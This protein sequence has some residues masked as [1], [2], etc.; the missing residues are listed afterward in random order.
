[1]KNIGF[2]ILMHIDPFTHEA[3]IEA[4]TNDEDLK[5]VFNQLKN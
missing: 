2:E 1:M 3:Y 5:E 4:Y